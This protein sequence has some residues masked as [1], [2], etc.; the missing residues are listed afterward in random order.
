MTWCCSLVSHQWR[1]KQGALSA[2]TVQYPVPLRVGRG[3]SQTARQKLAS[4]DT[5]PTA[6]LRQTDRRTDRQ[7]DRRTDRQTDRQ[8]K[9]HVHLVSVDRVSLQLTS[10]EQCL[11][12]RSSVSVCDSFSCSTSCSSL[13]GEGER[14][15]KGGEEKEEREEKES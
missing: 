10:G 15:R 11:V 1:C 5:A 12:S 3:S 14:G 4:V 2:W 6:A 7:T 9:Y 8:D 13:S